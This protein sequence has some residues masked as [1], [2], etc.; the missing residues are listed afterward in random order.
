MEI[1]SKEKGKTRESIDCYY[2]EIQSKTKN[3][4][5][6]AINNNIAVRINCTCMW[7]T[8]NN[9]KEQPETKLCRHLLFALAKNNIKLPTKYQNKRNLEIIEKYK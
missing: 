9:S 4:C 7:H 6:I 5:S 3:N 2:F 1:I 8:I